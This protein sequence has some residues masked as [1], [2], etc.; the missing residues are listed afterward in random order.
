MS[1]LRELLTRAVAAEASDIHITS[2]HPPV[3][4]VHQQLVESGYEPIDADSVAA[5]C[6]EIMPAHLNDRFRTHHEADFSFAEEG[7]GRFRVNAFQSISCCTL[8]MRYVKAQ[9]PSFEDLHLPPQIKALSMSPRGIILAAGTTGCG[10]STTLA[11]IVQNI[12]ATLKRR[13][14]TIEDPIE[15]V[16]DNAMSVV[17]QREVGL[18]TI[19]FHAGLKH[20]LRQDP[21][22]IMIGEMRDAESFMAA[23]AAAETGHL[24]LTT[25]HT[26]T[27]A[28]AVPRILDFFPSSERD[29]LRMAL[30]DNLR[31]VFCQRL[32]PGLRGGVRP[33][34]EILIN[35]PTVRKLVERNLIEKLSAAIET[36]N[37]D[38]MQTFNQALF[39][40]IK[41]GE[42]TEEMGLRYAGNPEAL[43]M[44]LKG[45]FLDEARRILST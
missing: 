31:A 42:I 4:R 16:F 7:V 23:L 28:Q 8:A 2:G 12:N 43:R 3:Y 11:A 35:T 17:S 44:N 39:G 15:Y 9:I 45:I 33:A 22:V 41:G 29:P 6:H 13:I 30:A 1:S 5:L 37:E 20:V 18:D 40:M 19:S 34:V 38:G 24:V 10:K 36:G 14:I 21:D 25:L 32:V 27:A 26:G